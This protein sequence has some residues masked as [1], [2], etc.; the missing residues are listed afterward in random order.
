MT[1]QQEVASEEGIVIRWRDQRK[2]WAEHSAA[3]LGSRVPVAGEYV[4]VGEPGIVRK[5]KAVTW[6]LDGCATITVEFHAEAES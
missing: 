1:E 2:P 4:V 5:V 3:W 6:Q